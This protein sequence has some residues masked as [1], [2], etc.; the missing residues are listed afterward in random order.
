ML[1]SVH[2]DDVEALGNLGGLLIDEI[3]GWAKQQHEAVAGRAFGWAGPAA[4]PVRLVHDAVTA[5]AYRAVRLLGRSAGDAVGHALAPLAKG[6]SVSASPSGGQ[7]L[8]TL[9]AFLGDRLEEEGSPLALPMVLRNQQADVKIDRPGLA[10]AYPRATSRVVVLVHGLGETDL[11]WLGRDEAGTPW[12]YAHALVA[13]GWTGA[14]VRYNTGRRISSNGR[15]LAFLLEEVIGSWPEPVSDLALIGHSMGGLVIRSSCAQGIDAG[16]S[17]PSLVRSCVYLGSPHN[18]A[19][20]EQGVNALA[21]LVGRFPDAGA[22]TAA[23]R[24]RSAGIR[25]LGRGTVAD[26]VDGEGGAEGRPVAATDVSL[27]A[28]ARHH[29]VAG[30]LGATGGN[31]VATFLGDLMVREESA[32]G[33]GGRDGDALDLG[34]RTTFP[35]VNHYALLKDRRV[36]EALVGWLG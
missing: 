29:L 26:E 11:S 27:L 18:G 22:V 14:L 19:P 16:H 15:S 3:A 30:Q 6:P 32:L 5:R 23:L 20:L 1:A 24:L 21:W 28:S 2:R 9:D 7:V 33:L 35:S 10:A 13:T 36:A 17:W 34:E 12:S 4:A 25:D 8:A 31:R